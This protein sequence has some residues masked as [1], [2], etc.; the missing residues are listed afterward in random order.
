MCN[1][2]TVKSKGKTGLQAKVL[3]HTG[4]L[5]REAS[6]RVQTSEF[7]VKGLRKPEI[8][9]LYRNIFN[10]TDLFVTQIDSENMKRFVATL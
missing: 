8:D 1:N 6:L 10:D 4:E 3:Q 2:Y 5:F 9:H 7:A